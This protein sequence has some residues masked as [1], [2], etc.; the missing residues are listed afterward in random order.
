[1]EAE[2]EAHGLLNSLD[3]GFLYLVGS[4]GACTMYDARCK[5]AVSMGDCNAH[6]WT[7]MCSHLHAMQPKQRTTSRQGNDRAQHSNEGQ[8]SARADLRCEGLQPIMNL[9]VVREQM[10]GTVSSTLCI[11]KIK[12]EGVETSGVRG[13]D[14]FSAA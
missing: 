4:E 13:R 14:G 12:A 2:D 10:L 5:R 7:S 8:P 9:G 3:V 6:L 1:V 11:R